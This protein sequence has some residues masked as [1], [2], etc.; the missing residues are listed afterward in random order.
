MLPKR[1]G[2]SFEPSSPSDSALSLQRSEGSLDVFFC[3]SLLQHLGIK[4]Q[5]KV[6]KTD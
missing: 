1:W 3:I 5:K 2:N 4:M 6:R